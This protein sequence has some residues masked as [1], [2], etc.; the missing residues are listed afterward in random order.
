MKTRCPDCQTVFRVTP[1]QIKA[2]A[3]MVRCGHCQ[4]VFDAFEE[5]VDER[6]G[7]RAEAAAKAP[8]ANRVSAPAPVADP[9]E[10]ARAGREA[11]LISP[12]EMAEIPGYSKWN[13]GI[14]AAPAAFGADAPSPWPFV[15]ASAALALVL[16]GQMLFHFRTEAALAAPSLRP[17]IDAFSE[18]LGAP[19]QLPR[20]ADLVSIEASD[21]QFDPANEDLL[22]LNA[23]LRNKA[24]H[25]QAYPSLELTLTDTLDAPI[26]R[27]VFGPADYLPA[28]APGAAFPAQS[29]AG[30]RLWLETVEIHA[31]GY[32]L[33]VFYP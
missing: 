8:A 14:V 9:G 24:P 20:R 7:A 15:A 31:A 28:A 6:R 27:R 26:A 13:E 4:A 33:F 22:V 18:A 19:L 10:A 25:A 23:T 17:A 1:E 16:A 2:R 3:G 5:L 30:V 29:D 11:G 21:L 12:R 32:R